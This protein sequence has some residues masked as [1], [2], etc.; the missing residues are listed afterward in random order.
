MDSEP[1]GLLLFSHPVA[2]NICYILHLSDLIAK[3]ADIVSKSSIVC[4]GRD[5]NEYHLFMCGWKFHSDCHDNYYIINQKCC[6]VQEVFLV[7]IIN[8]FLRNSARSIL[9]C[10]PMPTVTGPYIVQLMDTMNCAIILLNVQCIDV[11]SNYGAV[12]H[13]L[14]SIQPIAPRNISLFIYCELWQ[15]RDFRL[16]I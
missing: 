4:C 8:T 14:H 3:H 7:R 5:M 6:V 12:I 16:Q 15:C 10:T 11:N 13:S 2:F 9:F 1:Q